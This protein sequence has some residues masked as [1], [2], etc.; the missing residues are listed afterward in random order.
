MRQA[1]VLSAVIL[2]G[3]GGAAPVTTTQPTTP[4]P[5][6]PAPPP[7]PTSW[8]VT[9]QIVA[10]GARTPIAGAT[11]KFGDAD[12]VTSDASGNYTVVTTDR[13]T[14]PLV[15][16]AP[17]YFTRET[18]L[19]G[20]EVRSGVVFDLIGPEPGFPRQQYLD[21]VRNAHEGPNKHEPSRRWTANP[22]VYIRTIW[23]NLDGTR[24]GEVRPESIQ[25]LISEIRRIVPQWSAGTL[26]AGIIES[27][28]EARPQ[29]KGWINVE[30][31]KSGNWSLLG[32]DPGMVQFGSEGT[33]QSLAILHE[34]GHALG[35]WHTAT[36][37][38]IMGGILGSC[39]LWNLGPNEA[40]IARSMYARPPGNLEDD[41][42]GP[43]PPPVRYTLGT[44]APPIILRC[45][46][47]IGR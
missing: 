42:D 4:P 30:Y 21:L 33:C 43:P 28:P 16:A 20:G 36:K 41:K 45:D 22:N 12:A 13:T 27:G 26:E 31:G 29:T 38:S 7:A 3:C 18:S 35:Y 40:A 2:A 32:E 39:T 8:A 19:A 5:V 11:I 47:L 46:S 1:F 34:F 10:A 44:A 14:K 24:G 17:G 9:G 37:N 6:A 25:F 15:I 23:R